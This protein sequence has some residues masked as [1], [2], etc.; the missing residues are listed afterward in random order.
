MAHSKKHSTTCHPSYT[1]KQ[2]QAWALP[3]IKCKHAKTWWDKYF[4]CATQGLLTSTI[5]L[6]RCF[7]LTR[8]YKYLNHRG[9]EYI[10]S[11][12]W[13]DQAFLNFHHER[14][15]V[16][17]YQKVWLSIFYPWGLVIA[18]YFLYAKIVVEGRRL[19]LRMGILHISIRSS[20]HNRQQNIDI[21]SIMTIIITMLH[22]YHYNY[23]FYSYYYN[24]ISC[25]APW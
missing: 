11:M 22:Y 23:M 15:M 2:N 7:S 14:N 17:Y 6:K 19:D 20:T 8:N 16:L 12:I 9:I 13:L 5:W 4:Y 1:G 18:G 24:Y 3:V 21:W 10:T 25:R